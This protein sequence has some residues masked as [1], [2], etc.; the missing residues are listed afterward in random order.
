MTE[1]STKIFQALELQKGF[2]VSLQRD[3]TAIPALAP[4]SGGD[5]EMAKAELLYKHLHALQLGRLELIAAPDS[6]VPSGQRPNLLLTAEGLKPEQRLLIMTHLDVVPPGD[7]NEWLTPPFELVQKEDLLFGRGTEDNQQ[8]LVASIFAL[9]VILENGYQPTPTVQLLF[10]ADEETGSNYG[11]KYLL[12]N[13][14]ELFKGQILALVPDS[15]KPDSSQLEIAEK[16]VLWLKFS[17]KGKQVHAST[18]QLGLNAMV[19]GSDLALRLYG[20]NDKFNQTDELF[21]PPCSTFSPTKR[22]ANVPNINTIPGSDVF[23]LDCR[24]LPNLVLDQIL[25][26]ITT[27]C[28]EIEEEYQVRVTTEIVQRE[29][30]PASDPNSP[31]VKNLARFIKQ[32]YGVEARPSGIGGGTVAAYL[33]RAGIETVVWSTI[34]NTMHMPNEYCRLP[35]LLGDAKVMALLMLTELETSL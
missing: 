28:R 31:L 17:V 34:D 15:G 19:A 1:I 26:Q 3:L 25:E 29:S 21:D 20:L 9:K 18:P 16:S 32:V 4:E 27:I 23:Y 11:I 6:R 2:I 14:P 22:E 8:S 33:R 7:L 10:V 24:I 5:G 12:K 13:R 35:N 30:S